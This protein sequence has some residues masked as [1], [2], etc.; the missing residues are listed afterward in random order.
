MINVNNAI[1]KH[2]EN[3]Y[4]IVILDFK[5]FFI[6][7]RYEI[8][9]FDNSLYKYDKKLNKHTLINTIKKPVKN[10]AIMKIK[11]IFKKPEILKFKNGLRC[12]RL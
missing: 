11:N 10:K 7:Q 9:S 2:I 1:K 3:K 5:G 8:V 12:R 4:S 6:G